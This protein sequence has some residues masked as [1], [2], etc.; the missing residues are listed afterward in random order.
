[1]DNGAEHNLAPSTQWRPRIVLG[2]QGDF[3]CARH[4]HPPNPERTETRSHPGRAHSDRA[5]SGSTEV[6]LTTP[7]SPFVPPGGGQETKGQ[8]AGVLS[9]ARI[10]PLFL[11]LRRARMS[12]QWGGQMG[13]YCARRT[14]TV[15][16]CA[17]REQGDPSGHP[18]SSLHRQMLLHHFRA[19]LITLARYHHC[20]FGHHHILLR[21]TSGEVE[22]LLD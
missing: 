7:S 9:I 21:Q 14:S 11:F 17:F 12:F 8:G 16:S 5:R 13:L 2:G 6:I 1:M 18:T 10:P 4:S 22:P 20:P 19:Q 15:V 3:N